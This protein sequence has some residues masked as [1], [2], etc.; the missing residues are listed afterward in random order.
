MKTNQGALKPSEAIT[1]KQFALVLLF[2]VV[3]SIV[4]VVLALNTLY[5]YEATAHQSPGSSSATLTITVG[6]DTGGDTGG[7][8]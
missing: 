6:V 1:R 2:T 5:P 3:F 4:S 7:D 8:R